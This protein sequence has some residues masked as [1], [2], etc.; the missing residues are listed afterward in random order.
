MNDFHCETCPIIYSETISEDLCKK[1]IEYCC[2][3]GSVECLKRIFQTYPNFSLRGYHCS[4]F[5]RG[6]RSKNVEILRLIHSHDKGAISEKDNACSDDKNPNGYSAIYGCDEIECLKFIYENDPE[7]FSFR[8]GSGSNVLHQALYRNNY[9]CFRFI[10]KKFPD[11]SKEKYI[12]TS[13]FGW[14]FWSMPKRNRIM[15][16]I[17]KKKIQNLFQ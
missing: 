12:G 5:I 9:E 14:C 16:Y 13:D 6:L 17:L 15:K 2:M 1:S 10:N 4:I 11:L 7:Q 8:T 3:Q